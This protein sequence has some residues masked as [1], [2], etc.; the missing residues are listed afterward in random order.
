MSME[1]EI[2]SDLYLK[3]V[4][5]WQDSIDAIGFPLRLDPTISVEDGGFIPARLGETLTGFECY[6]DDANEVVQSLGLSNLGR[7]GISHWGCAGKAT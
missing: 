4:S 1:I 6:R 5:E 7:A 3:T 2:L